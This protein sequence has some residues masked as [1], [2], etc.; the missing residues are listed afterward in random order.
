[1]K[2]VIISFIIGVFLIIIPSAFAIE[3]MTTE[4]MTDSPMKRTTDQSRVS[5]RGDNGVI[6]DFNLRLLYIEDDGTPADAAGIKLSMT[7]GTQTRRSIFD[8]TVRFGDP[9]R[10]DGTFIRR[11]PA[12]SGVAHWVGLSIGLDIKP[13]EL[14]ISPSK[15]PLPDSYMKAFNQKA[16]GL[17]EAKNAYDELRSL[18]LVYSKETATATAN[19]KAVMAATGKGIGSASSAYRAARSYADL[20]AGKYMADKVDTEVAPANINVSGVASTLPALEIHTDSATVS[21]SVEAEDA[22]NDSD[23][24]IKITLSESPIAIP[25]GHVEI[26]AYR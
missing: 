23:E 9:Q 19:I 13:S 8:Y 22:L 17:T 3:A 11:E 18:G 10:E 14:T 1:M 6:E 25:G 7:T 16:N 2:I 24:F 15:K 5:I 26:C 4:E 20:L 12:K 21:H